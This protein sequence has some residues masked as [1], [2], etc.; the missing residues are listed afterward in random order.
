MLA[1]NDCESSGLAPWS[2]YAPHAAQPMWFALDRSGACSFAGSR[3][4]A[5]LVVDS[6]A[7]VHRWHAGC[8]QRSEADPIEGI[9]SF[10]EESAAAPVDVPQWLEAVDLLPRTVGYLGYEIGGHL[11][12]LPSAGTDPTGA[13]LAVLSTYDRVDVW[14][15]LQMRSATI[16]LG[17]GDAGTVA[18]LTGVGACAP[19]RPLLSSS[20]ALVR[21]RAGF[22]RIQEAIR[23]G[24]IY[25]ANLSRHTCYPLAEDPVRAWARLRRRQPVPHGAYLDVG[26]WCV[27]SNSPEL[28]LR[29]QGEHVETR[30]IKGTRARHQ[31]PEAD[32]RARAEL[33][34]DS[35]ELAEHVMIVDLERND[36]GRVSVTGSIE[37]A[38]HARLETF[39]TL[40]HLVSVVRGRLR[41][42]TT[43]AE[44]L[45]ATFPGGSI[46]GAPKIRAV[47][48]IA[49]VE[50]YGRGVYTGAIGCFNGTRAIDLNVAIRTAVVKAGRIHYWAGGGIV[51]DSSLDRE[52]AETQTKSLAFLDALGNRH[53]RQQAVG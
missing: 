11:E 25:K 48:I 52:Y 12:R 20:A 18:P 41:P 8:W 45:R 40:H 1:T 21:Y 50:P 44:L 29:V 17:P 47:E 36:L 10:V 9:V 32:A 27:L 39:A 7:I 28:F 2:L 49:E 46:T 13:P 15:P 24:D 38:A 3:P 53:D 30:P 22:A 16:E 34:S 43:L 33:L 42:A 51:A 31:D 37:V 35:K 5:Q 6:R 19:A 14:D 23:S 26:D 4:Y